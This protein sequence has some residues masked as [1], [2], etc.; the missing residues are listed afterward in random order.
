MKLNAA[1]LF[2]HGRILE[3][4]TLIVAVFSPLLK[5]IVP[6]ILKCIKCN[7]SLIS[8]PNPSQQGNESVT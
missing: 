1:V 4:K 3:T 2:Q 5:A 8:Y 7:M 6:H